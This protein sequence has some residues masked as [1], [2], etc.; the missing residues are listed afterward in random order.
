MILL[1]LA[2]KLVIPTDVKS[3]FRNSSISSSTMSMIMIAY[4]LCPCYAIIIKH[5]IIA[6]ISISCIFDFHFLSITF[7]LILFATNKNQY[8]NWLSHSHFWVSQSQ[9][10]YPISYYSVNSNKSIAIILAIFI[11]SFLI[12]M[13]EA[14]TIVRVTTREN[15]TKKNRKLTVFPQN[16]VIRQTEK[17][18]IKDLMKYKL[19]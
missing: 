4:Y 17:N 5:I 10:L 12:S 13:S 6:I 9:T 1:L 3:Q 11:F 14:K 2:P 15:T 8:T 18:S 19:N 16:A 7:V